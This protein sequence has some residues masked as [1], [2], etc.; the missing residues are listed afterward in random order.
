[1]EQSIL[2]LIKIPSIARIK[3]IHYLFY[4]TSNWILVIWYF[5]KENTMYKYKLQH[6]DRSITRRACNGTKRMEPNCTVMEPICTVVILSV[7]WDKFFNVMWL[8]ATNQMTRI[9]LGVIATT[10]SSWRTLYRSTSP[11]GWAGDCQETRRA[12]G[13]RMLMVGTPKPSGAEI[14]VEAQKHTVVLDVKTVNLKA[15][16]VV[17][18]RACCIF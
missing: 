15:V 18:N 8:N 9:Q 2:H 12:E 3:N 13:L 10:T 16:S 1:M 17:S 11:L 4:I 14:G 6:R 5:Y 7:K